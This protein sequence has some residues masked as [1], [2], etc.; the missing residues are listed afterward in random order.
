MAID[1][2]TG[3]D[4]AQ[5]EIGLRVTPEK[6]DEN[7]NRGSTEDGGE[8]DESPF[9]DDPDKDEAFDQ[10]SDGR[11]REIYADSRGYAFSSPEAEKDREEVT[12]ER[13]EANDGNPDIGGESPPFSPSRADR[14]PYRDHPLQ[15]VPEECKNPEGLSSRSVD[16]RGTDVL[17]AHLTRVDP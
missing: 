3:D 9:P 7:G 17:T 12:Q 1:D 4:Q 6:G 11:D 14:D 8:R 10:D 5:G 16:I 15:H 13:T 2:Q